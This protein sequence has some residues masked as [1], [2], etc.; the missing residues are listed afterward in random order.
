MMPRQQRQVV[1]PAGSGNTK[2]QQKNVQ[3]SLCDQIYCPSTEKTIALKTMLKTN[4]G[5]RRH[6][7]STPSQRPSGREGKDARRC[8][9]SEADIAISRFPY[10]HPPQSPSPKE[11]KR[12]HSDAKVAIASF[13]V[14]H[15]KSSLNSIHPSRRESI[16]SEGMI[17]LEE[18]AAVAPA[19]KPNIVHR[20]ESSSLGNTANVPDRQKL[21]NEKEKGAAAAHEGNSNIFLRRK[22]SQGNLAPSIPGNGGGAAYLRAHSSGMHVDERRH[23]FKLSQ[24]IVNKSLLRLL[25]R[26]STNSNSLFIREEGEDAEE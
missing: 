17:T 22:E 14:Y 9:D 3:F 13:N 20:K 5:A 4:K 2:V 21:F 23:D 15:H 24:K 8:S 7:H 11:G 18:E 6:S 10:H 19:G 26:L 25:S 16:G 1:S 12:R